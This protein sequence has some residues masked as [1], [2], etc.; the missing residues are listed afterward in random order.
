[1]PSRKMELDV[2]DDP[3]SG[4][5]WIRVEDV[6]ASKRLTQEEG[7]KVRVLRR[8]YVEELDDGNHALFIRNSSLDP[9]QQT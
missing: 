7:R 1:M 4:K 8:A 3:D 6:E 9:N 5:T 2:F